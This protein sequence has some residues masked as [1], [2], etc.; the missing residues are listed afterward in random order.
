MKRFLDYHSNEERIEEFVKQIVERAVLYDYVILITRKCFALV[1]NVQNN[2]KYFSNELWSKVISSQSIDIISSSLSGKK[3][4]LVDD[5][6]IHG[7]AVFS[8]Y[9]KLFNNNVFNIDTFVLGKNVEYPDFYR[10]A[11]NK[12]Y[13]AMFEI[14]NSDWKQL[15]ND[16]QKYFISRKQPYVSYIYAFKNLDVTDCFEVDEKIDDN[17]VDFIKNISLDPTIK[18]NYY[19]SNCCNKLTS[20]NCIRKYTYSDCESF[21][22]PYFQLKTFLKVDLENSWKVFLHRIGLDKNNILNSINA[23]EIYKVYTVM[24]SSFSYDLKSVITPEIDKSYYFGFIDDLNLIYEK[25]H[26]MNIFKLHEL[27]S[28]IVDCGLTESDIKATKNNTIYINELNL[29]NDTVSE[30][31][32]SEYISNVNNLEESLFQ[33]KFKESQF[34]REKIIKFYN[35]TQSHLPI[36]IMFDKI[37]NGYKNYNFLNFMFHLLDVGIIAHTVEE[38]ETDSGEIVISTALKTGEQS[39]ILPPALYPDSFSIASEFYSLFMLY[40]YGENT[41]LSYEN[42]KDYIDYMKSHCDLRQLNL[43]EETKKILMLILNQ[44]L[45]NVLETYQVLKKGEIAKDTDKLLSTTINYFRGDN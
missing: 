12:D 37:E 24:L 45:V 16:I 3:I 26:Q 14:T 15:S 31:E 40:N 33:N 42:I 21:Y 6:M 4:L 44:K 36:D 10:L 32:F 18:S 7:R 39:Y 29:C 38:F 11:L 17:I 20:Y 23:K 8:L 41:H 9:E 34:S 19:Y 30:I 35:E 13:N 1:C 27:E 28:F 5:I 43:I 2:F 22:I 25:L